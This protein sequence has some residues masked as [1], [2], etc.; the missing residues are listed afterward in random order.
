M[1]NLVMVCGAASPSWL[2]ELPYF[3][4]IG[5]LV[6][7][8]FGL[9]IFLHELGH[10][11]VA[12][13]CKLHIEKFSIGFGHAIRKWRWR[14]IDFQL[15]WIPFGGFVALPQLD[16]SDTPKTSTG[17]PLPVAS[18]WARILTAIAGP[19]ANVVYGL[20]LASLVW[21]FGVKGLPRTPYLEVGDVPQEFTTKEGQTLPV[22]EWD[23]GLRPGDTIVAI[24]GKG[25]KRGWESVQ[26]TILYAADGQV[27]LTVKR[28][29]DTIALPAYHLAPNPRADGIGFPF[30]EPRL[31]VTIEGFAD[32]SSGR[33]RGLQVGDLVLAVN[34]QPVP[35]V[36]FFVDQV[37]GSGGKP[38]TLTVKRGDRE[39]TI[40]DVVPA[41]MEFVDGAGQ[42]QA[43]YMIGVKLGDYRVT[44]HPTPIEQLWDVVAMT[45]KT[46]VRMAD[47]GNPIGPP[48]LSGPVGI[49]HAMVLYFREGLMSGL[50]IVA[51][52]AAVSLSPRRLRASPPTPNRS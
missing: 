32:Q 26:R 27:Q 8:F 44:I 2:T 15:G 18:P 4:V 17:Q 48:H 42:P 29:H 36:G 40:A 35:H 10:L 7:L 19:L 1:T 22:P 20:A 49:V 38:L 25:F 28:G 45:Q 31:P 51:L 52:H 21:Y 3:V 30:F 39:L 43:V 50:R 37:Q 5:V 24:N 33:D 13:K 9:C 46:I 11:L 41:R 23:A 6:A 14:N 16:P 34:G 12:M 47:K